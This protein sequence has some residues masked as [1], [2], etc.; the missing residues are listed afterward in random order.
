MEIPRP[1][2]KRQQAIFPSVRLNA[3]RASLSELLRGSAWTPHA[4]QRSAVDVGGGPHPGLQVST[5]CPVD[6]LGVDLGPPIADPSLP[7]KAPC[8]G[9]S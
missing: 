9:L 2:L 6:L 7:A 8:P 1:Q 4:G 5:P 3:A